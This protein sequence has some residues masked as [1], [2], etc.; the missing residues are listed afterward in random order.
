MLRNELRDLPSHAR[1]SLVRIPEVN[2]RINSSVDYFVNSLAETGPGS[3]NTSLSNGDRHSRSVTEFECK[4]L[5]HRTAVRCV[6]RWVL[7]MWR[8]SYERFPRGV[9]GGLVV[10]ISVAVGNC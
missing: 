3:S 6:A 7:R 4:D 8:S 10:A 5:C 1:A 2:P 9:T